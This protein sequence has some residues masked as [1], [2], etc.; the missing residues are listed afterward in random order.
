MAHSATEL[1]EITPAL[2]IWQSYDPVIKA[3]LFSTALGTRGGIFLV[4]PIRLE[5]EQLGHLQK[6]GHISG[7]VVTNSNHHRAA[8]W[9][10][11]QFGVPIFA[12]DDAFADQKPERFNELRDGAKAGDETEVIEIEGAPAG[13][14]ALHH[15]AEGGTLIIGDALINFDPYG[16]ALLPA[17]YCRN[18]K[19]MR[20]SLR[21][22]LDREIERIFFAHGTPILAGAGFEIDAWE[23]DAD[24]RFALVLAAPV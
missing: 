24:D 15:P 9:Y 6:R 5:N 1:I 19:Q 7:I 23:S 22:L 10:S 11:E 8:A 3:E 17:K 14:L 4:D 18:Q 12:H 16:F 21:K 2:R 13:E 20:S